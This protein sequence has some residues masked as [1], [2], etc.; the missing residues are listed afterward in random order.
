M[1]GKLLYNLGKALY[2]VVGKVHDALISPT[3]PPVMRT[4]SMDDAY[5]LQGD[6]PVPAGSFR[7]TIQYY[8]GGTFVVTFL[9]TAIL[10]RVFPK[11]GKKMTGKKAAPRRRTRRTARRRTYKR[12][13]K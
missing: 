1:V 10:M 4:E 5:N 9:L 11:L 7:D 13:K 2:S 3:Q 8:I 6:V 12:R